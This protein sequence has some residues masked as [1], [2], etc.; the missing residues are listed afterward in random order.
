M[1]PAPAPSNTSVV[2]APVTN[3]STNNNVIKAPIRNREST[4]TRYL[5][6]RYA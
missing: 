5:E 3:T 4:Q 6:N 1:A 2:N